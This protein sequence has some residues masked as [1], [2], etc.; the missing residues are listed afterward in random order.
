MD[1][2]FHLSPIWG[3]ASSGGGVVGAMHFDHLSFVVLHHI[4]GGNEISVAQAYFAPWREAVI[5]FRRIFA[6]IV[7]LNVENFGK[8]NFGLACAFVL[9]IIHGV[10][11]FALT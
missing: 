7:L 3:V 5:L 11:F 1:G 2:G 4:P 10:D 9:G 6:E 8:R